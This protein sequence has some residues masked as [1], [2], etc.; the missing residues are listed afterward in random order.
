MTQQ[1]IAE[2][3]PAEVT[4][5]FPDGATR[6]FARGTTGAEIAG[7]I[8]KSLQKVFPSNW[9]LS[10]A[11]ATTVVRYLQEVG[12]PAERLIA[13]GR[14]TARRNLPATRSRL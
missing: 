10:V 11:R 13:S 14:L 4:V 1:A 6:S 5:T 8:A 9:E 3:V 2:S 7:S 12:I